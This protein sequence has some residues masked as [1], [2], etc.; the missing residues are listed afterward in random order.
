MVKNMKS[1]NREAKFVL[2][3]LVTRILAVAIITLTSLGS[4]LLNDAIAAPQPTLAAVKTLTK[5]AKEDS[6]NISA[7]AMGNVQRTVGETR[8]LSDRST[9]KAKQKAKQVTNN[10]RNTA[11]DAGDS[12]K[13]SARQAQNKAARDTN[14]LQN[15]A[16]DVGS[17]IT[18]TAEDVAGN[19]K[20]S[21]EAEET[22]QSMAKKNK[23][24][25]LNKS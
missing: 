4:P 18:S 13:N 19:I 22:T 9:I 8:N 23:T 20:E 12:I 10:V 5:P 2:P 17:S 15:I 7:S 1:G 3:R 14:R 21:F 25:G 16:E 6:K 24:V 11:E